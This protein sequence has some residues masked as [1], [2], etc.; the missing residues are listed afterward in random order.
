M[1]Q[2]ANP[3]WL[4]LLLPAAGCC[5]FV[6]AR[7]VRQGLR[8][9]PVSRFP[10]QGRSWRITVAL[11]TPALYLAALALIAIAMARPRSLLSSSRRTA[12]VIAIQMVVDVSGSMEALDFSTTGPL[13]TRYRTRLD[14]VKETF[15][16]FIAKRP[17]DLIGLIAF[18]GYASTLAPLTS[19]HD[20]LLHVLSG[21]E[22]PKLMHDSGGNV[23]NEDELLTAIGDALATACARLQDAE[24]V[25]KIIVL[26]SDGD[27]NA[28]IIA[29]ATA[30][31]AARKLGIKVYTIGIGSTGQAPVRV[32]DEFGRETIRQ[33]WI[34]FDEELLRRIADSTGGVYYNVKDAKGLDN[35]LE[36]INGLETTR[37]EHSV[38][39]QFDE[40][41][42]A[43]ALAAL[44]LIL[45]GVTL[46]M[47]IA[48]RI[49]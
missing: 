26:L 11:L 21:A 13:G 39:R 25:S 49:L 18:G 42:A 10:R 4:L 9:G 14:V 43:Y 48:R 28:G 19:D 5:W 24:P 6:Y 12:D 1:F 36:S 34:T 7:R 35:A 33:A 46:N 37:V 32:T 23:L 47:T 31:D 41:F 38:I 16:A 29:P 17:D 44:L 2:F 22:I 30:I 45:L 20:A 40:Q 27:S 15:A 8:F 3:A